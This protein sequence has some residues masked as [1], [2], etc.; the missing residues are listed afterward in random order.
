[1]STNYI[2]P[3]G[4]IYYCVQRHKEICD[5][6]A[7]KMRAE[8]MITG[9]TYHEEQRLWVASGMWIKLSDADVQNTSRMNDLAQEFPLPPHRIDMTQEF[10]LKILESLQRSADS[11]SLHKGGIRETTR[12]EIQDCI[13]YVYNIINVD[14]NDPYFQ[15]IQFD[16]KG[17]FYQYPGY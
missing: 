11:P 6:A 14:P 9:I 7:N 17:L 10:K 3:R 5:L 16:Q 2:N 8:A 13:N 15:F 4:E 1:M 12:L